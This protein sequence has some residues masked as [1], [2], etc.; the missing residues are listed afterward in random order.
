MANSQRCPMN[1]AGKCAQLGDGDTCSLQAAAC[2]LLKSG[3]P[4][5]PMMAGGEDCPMSDYS[6]CA[7][8]GA[9]A[10]CGLQTGAMCCMVKGTDGI[11]QAA[12]PDSEQHFLAAADG[13]PEKD[14]KA[15]YVWDV[16]VIK[17]GMSKNGKINWPKDVVVA[18]LPLMNK[19]RV[20]A[21]NTS[22]HLSPEERK[23]RMFGKSTKELV[24]WIDHAKD[25]GT[26]ARAQFHILPA[27]KWLRDN[28]VA[29]FKG[30]FPD[31]FGFSV[32]T[33]ADTEKKM[34]AGSTVLEPVKITG[35][36]VDVVYDPTNEGKFLKMVAAE[37]DDHEED[38]MRKKLLAAIIAMRPNLKEQAAALE[39]KGDGATDADIKTFLTAAM[40]EE[41]ASDIDRLLAAI[42]DDRGT[43]DGKDKNLVA[44]QGILDKANLV[45]A[46][47]A[48]TQGLAACT[49][50]ELSKTRVKKMFEGRVFKEEE[51]TAAIKD[52]ATYLDS[53]GKSGVVAG[54]GDTR[55]EIVAG[56]PDRLQAAMDKTFGLTVDDKYKD[57]PA[58]D[59]LLHGYS[60]ITGDHKVQGRVDRQHMKLCAAIMESMNLPAAY[61]TSAVQF[62]LGNSMYRR[63]IREYKAVDYREDIL[64]SY[65]RN[66]S[67]FKTL[68]IIQAGYFGD[69]PDVNPE[70]GD[71]Q[72]VDISGIGDIEATYNVNQKGLIFSITRR[73]MLNDD[74]KTVTQFLSKLG[75][76]D[77]RTHARRAWNKLITNANYKGDAKALFHTDRGNLGSTA[78][79]NDAT[80]IAT[81]TARLVAMYN[82]TERGSGEILALEPKYLVVPRAM[83]E[84]AKALNKPWP[85]AGVV[86]PHAGRFGANNENIITQP[87][88]TDVN[89]TFMIA[90]GNDVELL[91]AA[92]IN[93][94]RE[95][96]VFVADNP[97]SGQMFLADKMQFKHRHEYEFE[98]AATEGFDAI[99][100]A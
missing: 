94:Q 49:L 69:L 57:V 90:D 83:E 3:S 98:I 56:E 2:A 21:L 55:V 80:G 11:L 13:D 73:V 37:P 78:L 91:E 36:Q 59:G 12:E 87:L 18:A 4:A 85:L 88:M 28:V 10:G 29:S 64:I 81:L 25:A 99:V 65:I 40:P 33:N 17:Y 71:Y 63:L 66:A 68:E 67:N 5:C 1:A 52:E 92:Y 43:G 51:L 23:K 24:G 47:I 58:F 86:N 54:V 38:T 19:A 32:D 22:Q 82:Q 53:L 70:T 31:L 14:E 46:G 26:S 75:R 50:P 34:V 77:R 72:E 74:L 93:G 8:L 6:G 41:K 97:L 61:D 100:A 27:A 44:A 39:A 48:L 76:A 16:Q 95:P 30:G 79:T 9:D 42:K 20:F 89:N 15:G 45:A 96:E 60:R 7:Q 62:V 84:I 35:I